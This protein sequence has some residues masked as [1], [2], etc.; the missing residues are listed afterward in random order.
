MLKA[1]RKF[2]E[3]VDLKIV[4]RKTGL[5]PGIINKV[6]ELRNSHG[7]LCADHDLFDLEDSIESFATGHSNLDEAKARYM[8]AI[9]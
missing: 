5:Y 2:A 4:I 6:Y 9:R 3:E 8:E 1:L 7:R